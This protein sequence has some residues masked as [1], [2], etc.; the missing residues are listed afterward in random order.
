MSRPVYW[1]LGLFRKQAH[2][3]KSMPLRARM[4]Y[5][6]LIF[7]GS[8]QKIKKGRGAKKNEKEAEKQMKREQGWKNA[9]GHGSRG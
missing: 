1:E 4:D 2:F 3:Q 7:I 9:R 6:P 5:F 8:I